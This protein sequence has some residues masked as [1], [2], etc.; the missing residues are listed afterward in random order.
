MTARVERYDLRVGGGYRMVLTYA[1]PASNAG[2]S[3][4]D[5]D[6]VE[7][8]FVE[9]VEDRRVVEEITFASDDPAFAGIMTMT[10]LLSPLSA[11]TEVSIVASGVP[12][13]IDAADHATGMQSSLANLAAYVAGSGSG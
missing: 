4:S 11:G 10:W 3:T 12:A 8:T 5:S 1:D 13:G 9:L 2:K 7:A 6:V